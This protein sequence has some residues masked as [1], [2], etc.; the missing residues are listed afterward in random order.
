MEFEINKSELVTKFREEHKNCPTS[1][2]GGR[3]SFIFTPTGLGT[4]IELRCNGCGKVKN[5][6]DMNKW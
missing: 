1:T 3:V 6:T 4:I 5:I 2:I